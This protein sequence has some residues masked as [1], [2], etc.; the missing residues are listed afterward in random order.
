MEQ[1]REGKHSVGVLVEAS[2]SNDP[3]RVAMCPPCFHILSANDRLPVP[4]GASSPAAHGP[5]N[6]V[7]VPRKCWCC[8]GHK[9]SGW[10]HEGVFTCD[11]CYDTPWKEDPDDDESEEYYYHRELVEQHPEEWSHWE[12]T[13]Y[14]LR[15]KGCSHVLPW[16]HDPRASLCGRCSRKARDKSRVSSGSV[17]S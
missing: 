4:H 9:T 11:K 16:L 8:D 7:L 2:H 15:C 12:A 6:H 10:M 14:G 1:L 17:A 3:V 13:E 5:M